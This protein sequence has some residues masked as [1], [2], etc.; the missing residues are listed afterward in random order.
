MNQ[1]T[2]ASFVLDRSGSMQGIKS[3]IIGLFN[4]QLKSLGTETMSLVTFSTTV[5][6]PQFYSKTK[7]LTATDYNPSGWTALY[8]AVGRTIE[9]MEKIPVTPDQDV[10]YLVI[11]FTD[12]E[13]NSS[14]EYT[15]SLLARKIKELQDTKRWTFVYIGVEMDLATEKLNI[16]HKNTLGLKRG[17]ADGGSVM[18]SSARSYGADRK[19]GATYTSNY[20]G[21]S[22]GTT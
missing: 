8:D 11:I 9:M 20:F 4:E 1:V 16:P 5:D 10:A 7:E 15:T 14:K 21:S 22:G 19:L 2:H 18:C 3:Q 13:D 12:G 6:E 17:L